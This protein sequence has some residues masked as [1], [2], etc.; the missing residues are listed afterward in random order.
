MRRLDA[1]RVMPKLLPTWLNVGLLSEIAGQATSDLDRSVSRI[2]ESRI[3]RPP[4]ARR[5]W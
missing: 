4:A 3:R 2:K 1:L 5:P